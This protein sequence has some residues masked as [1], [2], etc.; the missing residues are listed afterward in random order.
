VR[1]VLEHVGLYVGLAVYTA[2]GAKVFSGQGGGVDPTPLNT[3]G[4][5][6]SVILKLYRYLYLYDLLTRIYFFK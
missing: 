1:S 2:A 5:D 3:Q 4:E 6:G